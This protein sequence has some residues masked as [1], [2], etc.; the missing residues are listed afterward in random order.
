MKGSQN[1]MATNQNPGTTADPTQMTPEELQTQINSGL[2]TADNNA[3]QSMGTLKLVHQARVANLTRTAAFLKAKYGPD[4]PRVKSAQDAVAG[5]KVTVARVAVVHQQVSTPAPQVATTGWALYGRVFNAQIQPVT[6]Y[7]VFLVDAQKNYQ[8]AY[9]FAYTDRTGYFL[10]NFPGPNSA[11]TSASAAT[12]NTGS[13]AAAPQ[14]FVEVANANAMPVY[15]SA[16]AFQP[17]IGAA[18]YQNI[19]LPAGE[20]PIGDPPPE[21]RAVALPSQKKKS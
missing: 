17:V 2:A 9:G 15:L 13:S 10:I 12:A 11:N 18:T 7:T 1:V 20:K 5:E 14:L 6:G 8:Q 4:D 16:T 19:V 21:I 3:A